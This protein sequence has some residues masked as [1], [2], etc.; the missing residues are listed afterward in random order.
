MKERDLRPLPIEVLRAYTPVP[1]SKIDALYLELAIAYKEAPGSQRVHGIQDRIRDFYNQPQNWLSVTDA[2]KELGCCYNS[3][4][5]F[6]H[7]GYIRGQ[8]KTKTLITKIKLC[9]EDVLAFK[10]ELHGTLH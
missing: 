9:K 1:D 6:L 8:I 10:E 5:K 7:S 4:V 2:A 3:V